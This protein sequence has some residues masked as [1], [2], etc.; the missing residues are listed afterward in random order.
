MPTRTDALRI[1]VL[2]AARI[3]PAA[4]LRPAHDNHD[5]TV[6]AI[7]ARDRDRAHR[8]AHRHDIPT[9]H[10][11]Y[12]ALL[13]DPRIDAIYN[14]LPNGLH[15]RWT[16]A[17]LDAG[18]HVLCEKPFTANADEAR[19]VAAAAENSGLVVM[20]AFHYRYHPFARRAQEVVDSGELGA[21]RRV[22][23]SLCF[24]LP[25]FGDIRYDYSLAGGAMMDVGCYVL[26]L[27]RLLGGGEP[28]VVSAT[29]KLRTPEVDRAMRFELSFPAGH[30][31]TGLCSMW[32]KDLFR[33]SARA[34]GD[35]GELR[36]FNPFGPQMWHRFVVRTRTG[37]RVEQFPGR[38]TY[39][40]QLDAFVHAIA[41]GT[42]VLT[43]PADAITNMTALDAV[44]EAAGMP[45]RQPG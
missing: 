3:T 44:Y 6:A 19:T 32:S 27:L 14:P 34:V 13:D 8:Y 29:P 45:L 21:L 37:R 36:I 11:D 18:K 4:L 33:A 22:S 40:Y 26:H 39:A 30:S 1:G 17:A 35:E 16:L 38:P 28:T 5:V 23:A 25:R 41:T 42:P 2:G 31:G 20:E 15:G 10:D 24:P 12:Q 43:P 9:V 7:A